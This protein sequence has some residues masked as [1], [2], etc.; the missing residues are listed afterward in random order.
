ME[1][2]PYDSDSME[3]LFWDDFFQLMV[4]WWLGLVVWIPVISL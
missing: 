3:L 4:N 1:E 2:S